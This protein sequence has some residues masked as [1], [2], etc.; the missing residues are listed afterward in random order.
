MLV[1]L[2]GC[3]V[4]TATDTSEINPTEI[5]RG[6]RSFRF[7]VFHNVESTTV[8]KVYTDQTTLGAALLEVGLIE[9]DKTS[10]GLMVTTVNGLTADYD[11]DQSWWMFLI[12]GE[13]AMAGV[14]ET[15]IE[16]D[17]IYAFAY[18]TS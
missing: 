5:G 14:E 3:A 15:E 16:T 4:R 6:E 11:A 18:Q 1:I 12:D 8:W 17:R 2:S 10:F 9:G 13:M 7:E